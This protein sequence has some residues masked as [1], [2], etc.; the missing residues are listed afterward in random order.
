M[1]MTNL[2]MI[3]PD[4]YQEFMNENFSIQLSN[5]NHFGKIEADKVI[6]TTIN[7]DTKTPGGTTVFSTNQNAVYL[8]T[9]TASLRAVARNLIQRVH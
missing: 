1:E 9:I 7:R 8:W 2:E 6:K 4:I 3:Y 5:N